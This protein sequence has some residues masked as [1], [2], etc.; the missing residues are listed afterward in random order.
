MDWLPGKPHNAELPAMQRTTALPRLTM[1]LL[2]W[3][4]LFTLGVLW[5]TSFVLNKV[6]LRELPPFTL[7]FLRLTLTSLLLL[8]YLKATG[9][10]IRQPRSAWKG[11]AGMGLLNVLMPY[12]FTAWGQVQLPSG[13]ASIITASTPLFGV[14]F[15]HFLTRDEQMTWRKI[16]GVLLGIAGVA[17]IMGFDALRGARLDVLAQCSLLGTAVTLALAGIF[18]RRLHAVPTAVSATGQC[19]C[20]AVFSLPLAIAFEQPWT[21]ALPGQTTWIMVISLAILGTVFAYLIY[22]RLLANAGA[23]NLSLVTLTIPVSALLMGAAFLDEIIDTRQ[24]AGMLLIGTGLAVIDGRPLAWLR[25]RAWRS[26]PAAR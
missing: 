3:T 11:F 26:G 24:V 25:S 18:G 13:L 16:T 19:I 2:E 12:T 10:T 7:I 23:T 6:A 9:A 8:A 17:V 4:L 22:F 21:R 15:A 5:G 1:G 14:I 20:A